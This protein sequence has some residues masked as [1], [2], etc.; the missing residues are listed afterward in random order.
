M[1]IGRERGQAEAQ[2]YT[3]RRTLQHAPGTAPSEAATAHAA[4]AAERT[5]ALD[6]QGSSSRR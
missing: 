6:P 1:Q 5:V 2:R 4:G 3:Q